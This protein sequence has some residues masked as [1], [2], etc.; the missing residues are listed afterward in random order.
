MSSL[1]V[2][3]EHSYKD[4]KQLWTSLDYACNLKVR[5]APIVWMY[6]AAAIL[7]NFHTVFTKE[8]KRKR[9]TELI[10]RVLKKMQTLAKLFRLLHLE[11]YCTKQL[12]CTLS[13]S[14]FCLPFFL[15]FILS[16]LTNLQFPLSYFPLFFL[17]LPFAFQLLPNHLY[18]VVR[19]IASLL[20]GLNFVELVLLLPMVDLPD[21]AFL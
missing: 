8:G 18:K 4:L 17:R 15:F 13:Q 9:N 2:S 19:V 12:K 1:R 20:C 7:H 16:I 21:K 10:T 6:K 11:N 3:V 5:L 14:I